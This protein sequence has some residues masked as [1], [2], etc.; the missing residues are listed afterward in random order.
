MIRFESFGRSQGVVWDAPNNEY[1]QDVNPDN[2]HAVR[3]ELE[4]TLKKIKEYEECCSEDC[5]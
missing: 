4:E 3:N 5:Q 2:V 1:V